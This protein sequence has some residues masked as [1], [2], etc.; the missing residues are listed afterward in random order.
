M[1]VKC[2]FFRRAGLSSALPEFSV[3]GEHRVASR[4]DPQDGLPQ[5]EAAQDPLDDFVP[6]VSRHESSIQTGSAGG[7]GSAS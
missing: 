2:R 1:G 4:L 6:E 5:P 3:L 7:S